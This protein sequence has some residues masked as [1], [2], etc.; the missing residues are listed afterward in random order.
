MAGDDGDFWT[1]DVFQF[2]PLHCDDVITL[3]FRSCGSQGSGNL[4][5]D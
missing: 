4:S 5:E 3:F 1:H 2:S